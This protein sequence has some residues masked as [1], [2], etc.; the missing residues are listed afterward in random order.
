M[1]NINYVINGVLAVAVIILFILQFS[2]KSNSS[3]SSGTEMTSTG[4]KIVELPV[5]YVNV[6][7]LLENYIFSI[8]LNETFTRKSENVRANLVQQDRNFQTEVER[9]NYNI[10]NNIYLTQARAEQ[11][12]RR[13]QQKQTDLQALAERQQAELLEENQRI[14]VQLRDTIIAH[15][16]EYNKAKG[17]QIIYSNTSSSIVSPILWAEDVYNI[18]T[19][20]TDYLNKKWTSLGG[21]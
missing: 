19:E 6:D 7:S 5:A 17:F 11:E 18:T 3:L 9:F 14:N 13:L 21:N 12:Q 2:G 10:Q 16:K 15:L 8:D 20:F 4:E 1:K